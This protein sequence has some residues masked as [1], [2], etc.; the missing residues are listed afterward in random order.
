MWERRA[1]RTGGGREGGKKERR[2]GME[3]KEGRKQRTK[4]KAYIKVLI[5]VFSEGWNCR[6]LNFFLCKYL[7]FPIFYSNHVLC[8]STEVILLFKCTLPFAK[9]MLVHLL[10]SLKIKW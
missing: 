1:E 7:N 3:G 10:N 4:E 2:E 8:Y 5:V 6:H 9:N